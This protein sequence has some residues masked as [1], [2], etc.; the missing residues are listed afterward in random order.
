MSTFLIFDLGTTLFK[1]CLFDAAGGTVASASVAAPVERPREGWSQID[2]AAFRAAIAHLAGR[3]RAAEPAAM[4]RVRRV[5]YATQTNSF[6]LLD[7]RGE[8]VSPILLWNDVRADDGG[9]LRDLAGEADFAGRT[10]LASLDRQFAVA[11]LDWLRRADPPLWA[12]ARRLCLIGDYL[13]WWLTGAHVTEAAAAGLTG[14]VDIH[15][16]AWRDGP[17]RRLG[18]ERLALPAIG[19]AG[20]PVAPL[21]PDVAGRLGLPPGAHLHLGCLDQLAGAVGAGAVHP[22]DVCQ[23]TGTV[24]STVCLADRFDP[25]LAARGVVQ[26]P[27]I[28]P[29][30][31]YR[32]AFT[33][34]ANLLDAYRREHA[35]DRTTADLTD[36]AAAV[37]DDNLPELDAP[38]SEAAG[39]PVFR[40][41]RPHHAHGHFVRAILY[42]AA[43]SLRDQVDRVC[44]DGRP[45]EIRCA[46][47]GAR[48]LQWLAIAADT[49]GIPMIQV[50]CD[51]PTSRGAAWLACPPQTAWPPPRTAALLRP[52]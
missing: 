24:L 23:T 21:A 2:P 36:A 48:N 33:L 9:A 49:L 13:A 34:S 31:Y 19:R 46:G 6:L 44:P 39:R 10:G 29:G 47:G 15:R 8:P 51:Q 18:L 43:A 12:S 7:G 17:V 38:A 40:G 37:A 45:R 41:V 35:G 52:R 3:L 11:K 26:G 20:E 50:D 28:R 16:L 4:D 22:G 32:M 14:L 1:A 42:G 25:A 5:S 30:L 27:A